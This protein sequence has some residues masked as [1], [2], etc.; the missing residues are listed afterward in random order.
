MDSMIAAAKKADESFCKVQYVE[1]T[2]SEE[3]LG[4]QVKSIART[5]EKDTSKS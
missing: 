1:S 5:I 2:R 4:I 3:V